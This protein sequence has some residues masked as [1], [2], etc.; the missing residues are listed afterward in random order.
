[1]KIVYLKEVLVFILLILLQVLLLNR[2]N[3]FGIAT[4]VLYLYF[5]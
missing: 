3:V 4:P 5:Y 1:M 2:I